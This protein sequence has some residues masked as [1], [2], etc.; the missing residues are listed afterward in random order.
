M[1][2]RPPY[3]TSTHPDPTWDLLMRRP[4]LQNLPPLPALLSGYKLHEMTP[5]TQV[6]VAEV[7]RMAF[8]DERWDEERVQIEFVEMPDVMKTFVITHDASVIATASTRLLP[9]LYPHSGYLHYVGVHPAFQGQR[10]GYAVSLAVLHE[11]ARLGCRDAVL[12]TDDFRLPSVKTYLNLQFSPEN[13]HPSHP[14]RWSE[15]MSNLHQQ[16]VL[17]R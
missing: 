8:E 17:K 9:H 12:E 16:H 11:F 15:V 13:R 2:N 14:E 10:L 5:P 1:A 6:S 4:H 7:L 3:P